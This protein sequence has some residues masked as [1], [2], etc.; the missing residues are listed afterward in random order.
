MADDPSPRLQS[1][2][3]EAEGLYDPRHE[4]D[5]CG[6]GFV[7]DIKG[8]RSH[9]IVSKSLQVLK[10]LAHR[11][12]CGC[13]VN[14][15]DGAGILIQMPDAFL[16]KVV[17][18]AAAAGRRVRRRPGLPAARS[19]AS[20]RHSARDRADRR[21]RRS[22]ADRLAGRAD[23]RLAGRAERRRRRA[24][25]HA[26]VRRTRPRRDRRPSRRRGPDRRGD[27]GALR[28]QAVRDPQAHR[29]RG[30]RARDARR[31]PQV[32]LHRQPVVE[33]ADLQGHAHGRPDR[34]DVPG[35]DGP[36]SG[37]GAGA[38]APAVQHQH[39][40]VVAAGAPVPLHRAQRRDQHA[41]GQHQLDAR[42]RGAARIGRARRGSGEGPAGHP[43]GRQR[44]G[45]VRQRARVPRHD[46]A[47]AAARDPDDDS[48]A[49]GEQRQHVARAQGVL[50]V[51]L[52]ADG[53]VGR[54]G[55]DRVHRRHGHRRDSRSQRPQAV[56]LLRDEGRSGHHGVRSRRARHPGREH[57]A[58][59]APAPGAALPGGHGARPDCLR[60]RGEARA[61][62]GASVQGVAVA[63]DRHRR[64]RSGAVSAGAEPRDRPAAPAALRLYARGSP[65]A[66]R[67]DGHG[68]RGT[69]RL[70]GH[71]HVAGGALGSVAPALRLL[72]AGL[73]AGDESAA[74]R[75]PRGAGDVDGID[76]RARGQPPR[77]AARVVPA[78]QDQVSGDRQR[79]AGQAQARLRPGIP[80]RS[81]SRCCSTSAR[82][83]A[84][85]RARW[86]I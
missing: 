65:A 36:R 30:G 53:T 28:T 77:S 43:R 84:A 32:V 18:A 40:P 67:P 11:G 45:D 60:R 44:H 15:G 64:S 47:V 63:P 27:A 68:G 10:N 69:D 57:R 4:H 75:H 42:A 6:V 72:Q 86:R 3:P 58:Q 66:R 59:G 79:S 73:R 46:R 62:P 35:S 14:T 38:R 33:H 50:R 2:P 37:V 71:R 34:D 12:A 48:R 83:A 13:E 49:V 82:A 23:R 51:P 16:R 61:R 55:V 41:D 25:L 70:D 19:R 24:A 76:D 26:A 54:P 52:V 56:A 7:V 8:R 21:R 39:V 81:A 17:A 80:H 29:A 85:S 20:R 5:A 31:G 78:D 1:G 9:D 22:A 74:R